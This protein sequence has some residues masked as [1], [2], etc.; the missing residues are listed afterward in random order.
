MGFDNRQRAKQLLDFGM[1]NGRISCTDIDAV[2]EVG[3]KYLI[4]F[5]V[6]YNGKDIPVGQSL[7]LERMAKCWCC[8][9]GN[10]AIVA[11]VNHSV[12]DTNTDVKLASQEVT[13]VYADREDGWTWKSSSKTALELVHIVGQYWGSTKL[14]NFNE[15]S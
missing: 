14:K 5:E 2:I 10:R 15:N 7:L 8:K 6:K 1:S 13:R 9:P 11:Q 3:G 4:L 12:K